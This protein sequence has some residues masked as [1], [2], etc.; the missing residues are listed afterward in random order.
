MVRGKRLDNG[1]WVHGYCVQFTRKTKEN[2]I[3]TGKYSDYNAIRFEVDGK[4]IS[5]FC[6]LRDKN[7][8]RIFEG[9][10]VTYG[11]KYIFEIVYCDFQW[12]FKHSGKFM[13][14]LE[15]ED[16]RKLEV[17]GN[18]WDNPELLEKCRT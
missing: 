17:I 14:R 11:G 1:E 6:G 7:D 4:T 12:Q 9:D 2:Y 13:H 10:F 16:D 18:K 5:M 15:K 8:K 3:Y